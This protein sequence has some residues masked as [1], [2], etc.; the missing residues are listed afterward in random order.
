MSKIPNRLNPK[1][2]E[3]LQEFLDCSPENKTKLEQIYFEVTYIG[4]DND[5]SENK[6]CNVN[7]V[8]RRLR[9]FKHGKLVREIFLTSISYVS[10][11]SSVPQ[12]R[13]KVNITDNTSFTLM[14]QNESDFN[15]LYEILRKIST[16]YKA[17]FNKED[18]L[19]DY[20]H[21]IAT[22]NCK[23]HGKTFWGKRQVN[24]YNGVVALYN[25][26]GDIPCSLFPIV[27]QT[28][29]IKQQKGTVIF[30]SPV[31][32][33]ELRF[34]TEEDANE[35]AEICSSC[36]QFV[37]PKMKLSA[38]NF[39]SGKLSELTPT[40]RELCGKNQLYPEECEDN[41]EILCEILR[42][43]TKKRYATVTEK[44]NVQQQQQKFDK[45]D[46]EEREQFRQERAERKKNEANLIP[47]E[48]DLKQYC[49]SDDPHKLFSNLVAIGKGGFGQVF[50][51]TRNEDGKQI[52][53]KVLKHTVDE[54]G[55][56]IGAEVSRL[57]LWKHPNIVG[58]E[59]AWIFN[60]QVYI[61]ME[62]CSSGTLKDIQKQRSNPFTEPDAAYL[63]RESLKALEY[64]HA[65]GFLHRDVKSSN[66]MIKQNCEVKMIDF[67]LV[68]R[69]TQN[70]SNRAGSKAY[71]APEVI[72]Q[73]PYDEKVDIWSM[74]CVAQELVEGNTPYRELGMTKGLFKIAAFGTTGLRSPTKVS[75]EF[76][77]FVEKCLMYDPKERWSAVKLLAH[78]FIKKAEMAQIK[79]RGVK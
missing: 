70:P 45:M 7:L 34:D 60:S 74:G 57:C 54:R 19:H 61:A 78:P 6:I 43:Q 69:K 40:C 25:I 48:D 47:V 53:L 30:Q 76:A 56:K 29:I 71:M 49:K 14:M 79:T 50:S 4:T 28:E 59:G 13:I 64:I 77:D 65:E 2:K 12:Y 18:F 73:V 51:C 16:D 75:H 11:V 10:D 41:F 66:I 63:I 62:F 52:A 44:R 58:F 15:S 21:L 24:V 3:L 38:D 31:R 23:K 26:G 39:F 37:H 35:V 55:S 20:C 8:E 27:E 68:I 32:K 46:S 36:Q 72:R 5:Q 42:A 9:F 22:F 1:S 67:G 33:M 17:N